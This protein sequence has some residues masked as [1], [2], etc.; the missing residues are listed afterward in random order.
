MVLSH[1]NNQIGDSESR[2]GASWYRKDRMFVS[3][4]CS[5]VFC[6]CGSAPTSARAAEEAGG[7][8]CLALP[9]LRRQQKQDMPG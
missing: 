8:S 7:Q 9:S 3:Q 1:I 5:L 4:S 6:G 2:A